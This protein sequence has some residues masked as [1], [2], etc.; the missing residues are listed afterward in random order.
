MHFSSSS[1]STPLRNAILTSNWNSFQCF[2]D[3][4]AIIVLIVS[5]L[6]IRAKLSLKSTPVYC[7]YPLVISLALFFY[8][9]SSKL[10]FVLYTHLTPKTGLSLGL[11]TNSQVE[12]FFVVEISSSIDFFH[13]TSCYIIFGFFKVFWF[14]DIEIAKSI[15][16]IR[17]PYYVGVE[18]GVESCK[19]VSWGLPLIVWGVDI[20]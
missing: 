18:L 17:T 10:S 16:F 6:V 19:F 7:E 4:K 20:W 11:L 15:N 12:F 2:W 3:A 9:N 1:S 14:Y 13:V 5:N 8:T